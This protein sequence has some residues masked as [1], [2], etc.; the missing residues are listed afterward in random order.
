MIKAFQRFFNAIER[1]RTEEPA[2]ELL[3]FRINA[4]SREPDRL[5]VFPLRLNEFKLLVPLN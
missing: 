4:Q 3:L 5:V 2:K 1:A